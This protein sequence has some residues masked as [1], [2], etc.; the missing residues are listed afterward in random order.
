MS[1]TCSTVDKEKHNECKFLSM[2]EICRTVDKEKHNECKYL[3][4]DIA[5]HWR[6]FEKD[7]PTTT[8]ATPTMTTIMAP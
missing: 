5:S 4:N 8:C 1:E 3:S 7:S 2:S 6:I